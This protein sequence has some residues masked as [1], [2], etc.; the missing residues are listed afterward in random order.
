MKPRLCACVKALYRAAIGCSILAGG[1]A[2]LAQTRPAPPS[3][4]LKQL[5]L[6]QLM[7]VEVTSVSRAEEPFATVPAALAV[8]SNEDLRR[9]GA[10][11]IPEALRLLPGLHVAQQTSSAW[12]VSSRGFSSVNSEKLLV[13]SDT[14]SVYT[15]L[16]SGVFWDV[17]NQL[18]QDVERIEVI[19]GP[20]A[21]LWGSNAVNGVVNITTKSASDTQG[22]FI[23]TATGSEVPGVVAAR[24]GGRLATD[25]HYRVFAQ[26]SERGSTYHPGTPSADDWRMAHAG[27]RADWAHGGSDGFTVQGDLYGGRV[28]QIAPAITVIGRPGQSGPLRVDVSGG[29]LLGRWRRRSTDGSDLQVRAYYDR[30]QRDDPTFQDALDTFD[31]DL[32]HR[33]AAAG[34]HELTWGANYRGTWNE[35]RGKG[36]VAL[37]PPVSRDTAISGF[38]QDQIRIIDS[39]HLTAGTKIEH[40][41]FS[42]VELQPGGRLSWQQAPRRTL[43]AAVSRAVRVPTR[44][45]R[46]IVADASPPEREPLI[47]LVGNA[48]FGSERLMAYEVGYRWQVRPALLLDLAA[49]DNRYRGLASLELGSPFGD[50]S[51]D[52]T[53]LPV[54]YE[55]LTNGHARGIEA[56]ATYTPTTWWRVTA[57]SSSLALRIRPQGLDANGGRFQ[58]GATPR[59][60]FGLRSYADLPRGFQLDAM[61]RHLT[62]VRQLPTTGPTSELPAYSELDMRVAWRGWRQAELSVVGRNLLHQRHGEFG[63]AGARG[64]IERA[65][66]ARL[67]WGF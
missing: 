28:G 12:N 48:Q 44:L 41:D 37:A 33:V 11:S 23:A 19:R 30:T 18:L 56:L 51:A 64:E 50:P 10:T 53:V 14:R 8:V 66:S 3:V 17:Q 9:S 46:D 7:E 24:F 59:H 35:F 57:S 67:A 21:T 26:F 54:R 65:I 2:P 55:N 1:S 4:A 52:R 31:V 16:F 27:F 45:E 25:A 39:L 47:R 6:E 15:P 62:A 63:P 42:G 34:R 22:L 5:S 32:Q 40:N 29:N 61:F 13:L 43:W 60:Q 38:V 58:E 20:G 36:I 49:F